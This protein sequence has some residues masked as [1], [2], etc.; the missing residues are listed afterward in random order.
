MTRSQGPA[1]LAEGLASARSA[2]RS[3]TA[4]PFPP[5]R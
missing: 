5:F 4:P 1:R 2:T 3:M